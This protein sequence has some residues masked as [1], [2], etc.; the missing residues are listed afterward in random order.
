M[1]ITLIFAIVSITLAL[2]FYTIGVFSERKV[3]TLNKQHVILFFIGLIFDM[4]GTT[5]MSLLSSDHSLLTI[6]GIT[7]II[8]IALMLFH[9]FWALITYNKNNKRKLK[10]FH[11][12][13]IIVWLIWLI[14]YILGLF[15]GMKI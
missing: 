2:I 3:G 14:P 1:K 5:L 7:G 9:A 8:A 13:S 10:Q 6:H 11:K 12:F 15:L 4:T